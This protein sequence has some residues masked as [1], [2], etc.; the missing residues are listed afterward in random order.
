MPTLCQQMHSDSAE[1]VLP[2]PDLIPDPEALL[3]SWEFN[4]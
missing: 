4:I 1:T 2:K 3:F